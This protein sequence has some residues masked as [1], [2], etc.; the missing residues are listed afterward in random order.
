MKYKLQ[1][2]IRKISS[3]VVLII[4]GKERFSFDDGEQAYRLEYDLYYIV[5]DI[6]AQ[7]DKIYITLIENK[8]INDTNWCGEE[9]AT[10]F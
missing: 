9:Q 4:D 2:F 6:Q 7:T 3:P 8:H 5:N 1:D 10:F